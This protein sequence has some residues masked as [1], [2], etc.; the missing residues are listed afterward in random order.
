MSQFDHMSLGE[1]TEAKAEIEKLIIQRQK[2]LKSELLRDFRQKAENAGIDFN[3]LIAPVVKKKTQS[4]PKYR[5][6]ENSK[7]TWSGKGRQPRWVQNQ[8]S[9]GR[10]L[11]DLEV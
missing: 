6:P 9:Q 2:E 5:N 3:E 1:L 8:L 11:E 7:E 4:A 10:K